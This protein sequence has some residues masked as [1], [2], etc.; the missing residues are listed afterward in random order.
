M[1]NRGRHNIVSR[2]PVSRHRPCH[3]DPVHQASAEQRAQG[4][5]IVWKHN[6]GHFR[7]RVANRPWHPQ[8][9]FVSH[10][11]HS[12]R[13]LRNWNAA[14]GTNLNS[15]APSAGFAVQDA[16]ISIYFPRNRIQDCRVQPE[17]GLIQTRIE[18]QPALRNRA[19][20]KIGPH[21]RNAPWEGA[22]NPQHILSCRTGAAP[23]RLA[24][25]LHNPVR[26]SDL[27]TRFP[28]GVALGATTVHPRVCAQG[29]KTDTPRKLLLLF[30]NDASLYSR[31]SRLA[32]GVVVW[33]QRAATEPRGYKFR[34]NGKLTDGWRWIIF[35]YV[36]C[37]AGFSSRGICFLSAFSSSALAMKL[38]DPVWTA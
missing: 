23:H 24:G 31:T 33:Q 3:V 34:C 17:D 25:A 5:G 32:S 36:L 1:I 15:T 28:K 6:L 21:R 14:A 26:S 38:E 2:V 12:K 29:R 18:E 19:L 22:D 37:R 8:I 35:V 20:R 9:I 27:S 10:C 30:L 13:F 7:L 4:I 11:L 16:S